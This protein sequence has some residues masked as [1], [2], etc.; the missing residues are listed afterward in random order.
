M[1][2]EY[3]IYKVGVENNRFATTTDGDIYVNVVWPGDSVYP[4]FKNEG[5]RKMV[6]T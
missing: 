6:G 4:T 2:P 3:K 5:K 1:D